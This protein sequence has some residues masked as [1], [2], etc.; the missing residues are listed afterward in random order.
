M[1]LFLYELHRIYADNFISFFFNNRFIDKNNINSLN[2]KKLKKFRNNSIKQRAKF[3]IK[4]VFA[5]E[6]IF[7]S[8]F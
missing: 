2:L 7:H 5:A 6:I 3:K 4:L 1:I 8:I